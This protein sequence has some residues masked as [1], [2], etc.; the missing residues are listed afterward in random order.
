MLGHQFRLTFIWEISSG[1]EK[2]ATQMIKLVEA[3]LFFL[4]KS[5]PQQH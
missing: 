5:V 1:L 2:L 4:A 3:S